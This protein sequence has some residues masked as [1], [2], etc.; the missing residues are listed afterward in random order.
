M[1]LN[2]LG[3]AQPIYDSEIYAACSAVAG[4][5]AV[6]SLSVVVS[7]TYLDPIFVRRGPSAVL[8]QFRIPE[9]G[10]ILP[11]IVRPISTCGNQRHDPGEGAYLFLPDDDHLTLAQE[12]AT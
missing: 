11:S 1:G 8:S 7:Q 5:V 3:I 6:H 4:V 10:P 12:T 9:E 2:V